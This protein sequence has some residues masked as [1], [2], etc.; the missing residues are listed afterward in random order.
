MNINVVLAG[1]DS[2]GHLLQGVTC[3]KVA[4]FLLLRLN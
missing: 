3:S 4:D 1:Q 2:V